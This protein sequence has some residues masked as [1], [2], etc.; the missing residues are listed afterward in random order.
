LRTGTTLPQAA[1]AGLLVGYGSQLGNG[2]T[3]GHTLG[4]GRLSPRSVVALSLF[5]A[6]GAVSLLVGRWLLGGVA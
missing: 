2:C 3:S 4:L 1:A 6:V 5:V